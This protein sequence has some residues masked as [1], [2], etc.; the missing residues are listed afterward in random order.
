MHPTMPLAWAQHHTCKIAVSAGHG[1]WE[2]TKNGC[3]ILP[4]LEPDFQ[5]C[6][7]YDMIVAEYI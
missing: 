3:G 7:P 1:A 6:S 4:P 5:V 2:P